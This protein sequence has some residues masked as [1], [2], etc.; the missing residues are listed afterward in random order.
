[1]PVQDTRDILIVGG[2]VAGLACAGFLHEEGVEAT[3]VEQVGK[4]HE[5]VE[6]IVRI[7]TRGLRPSRRPT[8]TPNEG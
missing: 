1:M 4:V 2:G 6:R 7:T 3:V 8:V 5:C